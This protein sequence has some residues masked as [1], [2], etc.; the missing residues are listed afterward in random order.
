MAAS[1]GLPVAL[2]TL[3]AK[4]ESGSGVIKD[5]CE[6]NAYYSLAGETLEFSR[7]NLAALGARMTPEARLRGKQ[8]GQVIQAEIKLR[9]LL[10][11]DGD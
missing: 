6:A 7:N 3:G 9:T 4:Y 11:R 1:Q 5:D 2:H 8:R 10:K